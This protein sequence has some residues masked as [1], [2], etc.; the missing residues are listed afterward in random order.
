MGARLSSSPQFIPKMGSSRGGS[1]HH[2]QQ[3]EVPSFLLKRG[4]GPPL[5]GGCLSSVLEEESALC[6]SSNSIDTEGGEQNQ[7]GQDQGYTYS[8]NLAETNLVPLPPASVS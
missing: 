1:L 8:T 2:L 3:Q 7:T 4:S 6:V 5:L